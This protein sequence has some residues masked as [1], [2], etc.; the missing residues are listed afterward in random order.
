MCLPCGIKRGVVVVLI[1]TVWRL[2]LLFTLSN[3]VI[4]QIHHIRNLNNFFIDHICK[5]YKF[6]CCQQAFFAVLQYLRHK[7]AL[8]SDNLNRFYGLKVRL[9]GNFSRLLKLTSYRVKKIVIN[10]DVSQAIIRHTTTSPKN[11]GKLP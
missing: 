8:P 7:A 10:S 1:K 2:Y 3:S 11:F 6:K 4:L 5:Q 9:S